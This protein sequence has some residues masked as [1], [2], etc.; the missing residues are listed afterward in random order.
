M[1]PMTK[2]LRDVAPPTRGDEFKIPTWENLRRS[3]D[4]KWLEEKEKF[5]DQLKENFRGLTAQ[6]R[7]GKQEVYQLTEGPY[8]KHYERAFRELFADTGYQASVGETERLGTGTKKT[9]KL[10]ITLPSC[11][12]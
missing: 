6:Y 8:S 5:H 3:Y 4:A 10:F 12:N 9:K 2:P 1:D 11:F 7:S